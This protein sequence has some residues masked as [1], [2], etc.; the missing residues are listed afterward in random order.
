MKKQFYVYVYTDP[1]KPGDYNYGEYHFDYEPFYVGKGKEDRLYAHL[2]ENTEINTNKHK[3]E[4]INNIIDEDF[5]IKKYII[6]VEC[7]M[8]EEDAFELEKELIS[9]IGRIDFGDGPL[10]NL[11]GGG[12]GISGCSFSSETKQKIS[13]KAKE[14]WDNWSI[15]RREEI[16]QNISVGVKK[17]FTKMSKKDR[18]IMIE[19]IKKEYY[20]RTEEQNKE[21]VDK[22]QKTR[23]SMKNEIYTKVSESNKKCWE[24]KTEE[25]IKAF[26]DEIRERTKERFQNMSEEE[27]KNNKDR[28]KKVCENIP[29]EKRQEMIKNQ[30][31]AA[32]NRIYHTTCCIC[33]NPMT[34]KSNKGKYCEDCSSLYLTPDEYYYIL[35]I[36]ESTLISISYIH[37]P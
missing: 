24:N 36:L 29:Y 11:T 13:K 4:K 28:C 33:K 22:I 31:I 1:R 30:K 23:E 34:S 5:N 3:I 8:K 35:R 2:C 14:R 6:K 16:R 9:N 20:T 21:R 18:D 12:E 25:E 37:S 10:T 15:E 26:S 27:R 7:D 32:R 19:N 17:A